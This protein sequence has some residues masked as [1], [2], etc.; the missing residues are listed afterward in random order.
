MTAVTLERQVFTVVIGH[1]GSGG[2]NK[3]A[4]AVWLILDGAKKTTVVM[5]DQD[6]GQLIE[7]VSHASGSL[8]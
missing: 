8:Q 3:S 7:G 4:S 5:R 1:V 6:V 2:S